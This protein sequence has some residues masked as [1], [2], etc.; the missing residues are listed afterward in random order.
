[1]VSGRPGFLRLPFNEDLPVSAR[2]M[3]R[4]VFMLSIRKI[5]IMKSQGRVSGG[6]HSFDKGHKS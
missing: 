6:E 5:L 2:Q 4:N 3:T 1:M